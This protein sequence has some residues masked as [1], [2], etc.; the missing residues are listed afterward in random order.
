MSLD[1]SGLE[2]D[3]EA[4]ASSPPATTALCAT[5][6]A[7]AMEAY[8][9]DVIPTC[10][11]VAAAAAALDAALL[12]AFGN[13]TAAATAAAMEAAFAAFAVTVGAGMLPAYVATVPPV[14][15]GFAALFAPPFPGTHAAAAEGMKDA[16]DAWMTAGT[17]VL[18]GGGGGVNWG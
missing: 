13:T 10:S 7:D 12:T 14:P 6:W 18:S 15:V 9:V 8:A 5:A 11:T 3:L 1:P 16:I 17:A 4:L 2:I